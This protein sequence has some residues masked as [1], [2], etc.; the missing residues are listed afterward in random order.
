MKNQRS[1]IDEL[2]IDMPIKVGMFL[3]TINQWRR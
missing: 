2:L 3:L 1:K